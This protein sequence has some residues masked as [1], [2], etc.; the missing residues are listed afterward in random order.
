MPVE[1]RIEKLLYPLTDFYSSTR[2]PVPAVVPVAGHTLPQPYRKLLVHDRDMTPTLEEYAGRPI[3]LRPLHV[4]RAPEALYREVLLVVE[5]EERP[6]AFGAIR[7]DLPLFKGQALEQILEGYLPLGSI[8]HRNK[9]HHTSRPTA[10]FSVE[11]EAVIRGALGLNGTPTLYGRHNILYN[12]VGQVLAEVVE[13]L[14]PL[15]D[16]SNA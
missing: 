1:S 3:H 10:F 2:Q 16:S 13:I 4:R 8:L 5:G 15:G 12:D 9:I 6:V 11:P 14:P 7:I